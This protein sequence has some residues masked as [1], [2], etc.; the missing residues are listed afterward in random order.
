MLV[1][2]VTECSVSRFVETR[3]GYGIKKVNKTDL[4]VNFNLDYNPIDRSLS[5]KL[6]YQPYEI[7]K[8]RITLNDLGIGIASLGLF[9]LVFYDNWDHD[10]TF[11]L[12]DDTFDWYDSELWEKVVLIG[13]PA[14]ILL[15]WAFSYPFDRK[16]VK[17]REQPLTE[18]PY[19]IELPDHSNIGVNYQT[20]TG[21]EKIEI[22]K[23]LSDLG[24]QSYLQN[25]G[26]LK[27]RATTEVRGIKYKRDYIAPIHQWDQLTPPR[28][29]QI[30]IDVKWEDNSIRHGEQAILRITVKNTT[31]KGLTDLIA[32]TNSLNPHFNTWELKFGNIPSEKSVTRSI[33]FSTN[34]EMLSENVTVNI[35]FK[36]AN[37]DVNQTKQTELNITL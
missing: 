18:H 24:N 20:A 35:I 5:V 21:N 23:F 9:G 33:G 7:H 36:T 29:P 2:N 30:E 19:R 26:R 27:F 34:S 3:M 25:I 37:E 14:D 15:Y 6:A 10:N 32:T 13:V 16:L 28:P 12:T 11:D 17:L 1:I 8:P 4:K 22:Q 31:E